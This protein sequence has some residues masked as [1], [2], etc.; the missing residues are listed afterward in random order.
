MQTPT[1][2]PSKE[3]VPALCWILHHT[4]LSIICTK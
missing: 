4:A 1:N 2:E 3:G